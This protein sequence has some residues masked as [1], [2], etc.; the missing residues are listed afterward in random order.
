[1]LLLVCFF[2]LPAPPAPANNPNLPVNINYVYGF[3]DD[4]AQSWM[5]PGAYLALLLVGLPLL[6]YLPTHLL[7]TRVFHPAERGVPLTAVQPQG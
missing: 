4:K 7:F 5:A 2:F 3:S 6:I 1:V